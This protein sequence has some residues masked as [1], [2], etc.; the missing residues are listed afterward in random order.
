MKTI[1]KK[2][3]FASF[4][5][6]TL[7]LN[8]SQAYGMFLPLYDKIKE[9]SLNKGSTLAHKRIQDFAKKCYEVMTKIFG[10]EFSTDNHNLR[11]KI[12]D[13]AIKNNT[14]QI[15]FSPKLAKGDAAGFNAYLREIFIEEKT[16][17]D[18]NGDEFKD[19]HP[20]TR[21]LVY[22]S[23]PET[24]AVICHEVAHTW[25]GHGVK[26]RPEVNGSQM[27]FE[28]ESLTAKVLNVMGDSDAIMYKLNESLLQINQQSLN[29]YALG[30]L[31]GISG[32]K[33]DGLQKKVSKFYDELA[34]SKIAEGDNQFTDSEKNTIHDMQKLCKSFKPVKTYNEAISLANKI[35]GKKIKNV[36]TF[37][38]ATLFD[39][40]KIN[41]TFTQ[42]QQKT[43]DEI[44]ST[45][46][47]L[48]VYQIFKKKNK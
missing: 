40:R 44:A 33:D 36:S 8:W 38:V 22:L 13:F 20:E 41:N 19:M 16:I 7:L 30:Y 39:A 1:V 32:I 43:I 29:P 23:I 47:T 18:G 35:L 46:T 42:G 9:K 14:L 28:A 17:V 21:A 45:I 5:A 12:D 6:F 4:F 27:E 48:G 15:Y 34:G 37:S 24:R 11:E 3:I 26:F 31:N 2:S 10:E 25:L